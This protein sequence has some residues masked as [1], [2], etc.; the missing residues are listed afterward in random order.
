MVRCVFGSMAGDS[1]WRRAPLVFVCVAL[2]AFSARAQTNSPP[3]QR[4]VLDPK[5]VAASGEFEVGTN[6]QFISFQTPAKG[7]YFC[8]DALSS[9]DD[10]PFAA[11]A[12]LE[13]LDVT[14]KLLDHA[15]WKIVFVDS[16]ERDRE[17]GAATN[18]I[19][20][21]ASTFWQT[22]WNELPTAY[23]HR[24]IIDLGHSVTLTG[25]RYLPRQGDENAPGR[26]KGFQII[27][28]E[29]LKLGAPPSELLPPKVFLF[30]YFTDR[31]HEGLRLAWSKDG[32]EWD[33]LNNGLSI[34]SPPMGGTN[35]FRDPCIMQGPDGIF[36]VVW[37]CA[38]GGQAI[39]YGESKD[40][41]HWSAGRTL[42]VMA[43]EPNTANCW[44]PEIYWDDHRK[45]YFLIWASSITNRFLETLRQSDQLANQRI[46]STTT[47][48]FKTFTPTKLFYDPG[49]SVIDPT[50]F[51]SE[52]KW[53]LLVK[54]ETSIPTK[55]NLRIADGDDLQGPFAKAHESFSPQWAEGPAI[56]R[57]EGSWLA[58]FHFYAN[59]TWGALRTKDL[60]TWQDVSD[61]LNMP[62]NSHPGTVIEVPQQIL[63]AMWQAGRA[64]IGPA[65]ETAD[66]GIGNWIWSDTV[67][68]KQTCRL[69]REFDV[70]SGALVSLA[71]LH[72]TA[73]NGYRLFLDGLEIGRGG[74]FNDLT[75]YNVTQL[76]TPGRHVL[77]VEGFNDALAAGV[78]LGM[79][80]QM[81]NGQSIQILSDRSWFVVPTEEKNWT[82][83][84]DP[85]IG[86]RHAHIV[87][88]AGKFDWVR[89]RRVL[90]SPPVLPQPIYFWQRG[91]FLVSLLSVIALA[92][93]FSIRQGLK[94]A[95]QTRSHK[96]LE[97]ERDRIA[98]DIHDDLGAGLT[99]LTLLGELVLRETPPG[100]NT[101]AQ[102]DSLCGKSRR[103]LGTMDELVWTVNSRRDTV[104]DF[105]AFV[106]E[107]AQEFLA[108]TP[109]RCRLDVPDD[110]PPTPLDLPAR[111]NL[112][113]AVKEAVRN[114]ARHSGASELFL[115]IR[116]AD[117]KLVVALEDNGTRFSPPAA[118]SARNGLRNMGERLSDVGGVCRVTSTP[119]R[120]CRVVFS[121]P[122]RPPPLAKNPLAAL[123]GKLL[124]RQR[125]TELAE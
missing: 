99:Q 82:T 117:E 87:A 58:I 65:P 103:L 94:L 17:D 23:P 88:F 30:S 80:I 55:K 15:D 14:G 91:W 27:L 74:D 45:E 121:L 79:N 100:A 34:Y 54:D 33:P 57:T 75:E 20:G 124:R 21:K 96:L 109:I 67:Q 71:M 38:W 95:V 63:L 48:D 35:L 8:F 83:R 25:F 61:R 110:L 41:M 104:V 69:W 13:L 56:F 18:A 5:R 64:E 85:R 26:I 53:R 114:A 101:R 39:G 97:R 52:G 92:V 7:R 84:R 46:F 68:D 107:H 93:I 102:L 51:E 118:R 125:P 28:G 119:T 16:E 78:I 44:A 86:W 1:R 98:R 49:F 3:V 24:L 29:N 111:R 73:D 70:P 10:K 2:A 122:L 76:V 81:L 50:I 106:C 42:P 89:P 90:A 120:G 112:L 123:F 60:N 40:L 62:P 105:A 66:L 19:D 59:N 12:E 31:D 115:Q 11:I 77:A 36:R 9:L 37:T 47:K 6:W 4:F 22:Q 113:L 32:Y 116:V 43:D 72:I 108:S